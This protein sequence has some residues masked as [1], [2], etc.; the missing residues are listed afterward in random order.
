[1]G[2]M[3]TAAKPEH[4]LCGW[5]FLL[6]PQAEHVSLQALINGGMPEIDAWSVIAQ[7]LYPK[8]E[9]RFAI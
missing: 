4:P 6:L 5:A 3:L 1:M 9:Q 8:S 7:D 2:L